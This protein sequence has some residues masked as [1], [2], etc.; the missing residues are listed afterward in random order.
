MKKNQILEYWKGIGDN[1]PLRPC[2]VPYQHEGSTYAEDGIRITGRLEWIEAVLSRMKDLLQYENSDTRLQLVLQQ[3]K[4]RETGRPLDGY[5]CYVQVH[6]RG[7][8]AQ[9]MNAYVDA[10]REGRKARASVLTEDPGLL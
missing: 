10:I 5:N 9:M 1:Q 2:S 6:E 4:D 8:Q 3:S 7:G